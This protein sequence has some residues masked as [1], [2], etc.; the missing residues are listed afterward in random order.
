MGFDSI[1]LISEYLQWLI[2]IAGGIITLRIIVI[3][4]SMGL[5]MNEN[6]SAN[7]IMEKIGKHIKSIIL[8][9][10]VEAIIELIQKYY[11]H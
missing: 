8:A 2:A 7:D 6:V 9:I 4:I 10:C 3:V 1:M 11:F 5:S